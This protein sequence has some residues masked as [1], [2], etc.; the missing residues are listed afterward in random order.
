MFMIL[1]YLF[2]FLFHSKGLETVPAELLEKAQVPKLVIVGI[3]L[4]GLGLL[5]VNAALV[6]WFIIRKRS[7]GIFYFILFF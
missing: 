2:I 7:K 5:L 4:A 1:F 6:A 3:G